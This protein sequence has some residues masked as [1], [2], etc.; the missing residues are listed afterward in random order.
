M[1]VL[2]VDQLS[3]AYRKNT[4]LNNVSFTINKGSLTSIV[5]PNGAGKSTLIKVLL[6][7][8]PRLSGT[9]SFFETSLKRQKQESDTF[10]NEDRLIGI[11]L[12]MP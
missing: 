4:V 5:G 11:F 10:H 9:T 3:A 2:Q 1:S 6:E 7:L 12:R 8:H